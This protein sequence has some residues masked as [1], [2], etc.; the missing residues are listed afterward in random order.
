MFRALC[1][2][3]LVVTLA[4][5]GGAEPIWAPDDAVS[6]AVYRHAGPSEIVLFTM[7]KNSSG[8]GWHSGLMVNASQRVIFD[9]AGTFSSAKTPERNDV[10]FGI[11]PAALDFYIDYHA[12]ETY[13][14]HIQRIP[15]SPP[16]AERALRLVQDYGAVPKAQCTTSI[17]SILQ[18][19]PGFESLDK[20]L[21]PDTARAAVARLPGVRTSKA[22]DDSP[23]DRS[24]LRAAG[25]IP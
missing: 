17:T 13:H 1:A 22:Y 25:L 4:A 15:V 12:R 7:I 11:T 19:L 16:V 5:C 6:R 14:V 18:Q 20:T 10:F 8:K 3:S 21:W 23:D 24:D 9:P 2:L